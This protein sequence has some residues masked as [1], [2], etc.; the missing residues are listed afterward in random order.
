MTSGTLALGIQPISSSAV[1][2]GQAH[3]NN[4]LGLETVNQTWFVLDT[5]WNSAKDDT[6]AHDA[7]RQLSEDI[8]A[9]ATN[10]DLHLPYIF[11]NDASHDQAVIAGYGQD[12][13]ERLQEVQRNYDPDLVFQ[14]LVPGGFKLP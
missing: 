2:Q 13:I 5:G 11:M 12:N 9:A 4:A 1:K 8:K 10:R 6:M 7:T 3:G 14:K